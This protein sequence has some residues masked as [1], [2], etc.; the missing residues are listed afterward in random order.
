MEFGKF[1]E[2]NMKIGNNK[3]IHIRTKMSIQL[4]FE[5]GN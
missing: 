4:Y 3:F 1:I 5:L 2:I